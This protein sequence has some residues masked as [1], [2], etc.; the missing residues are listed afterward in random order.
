M[1][2]YTDNAQRAFHGRLLVYLQA[3]GKEETAEVEFSA[4]WLRKAKIAI[5]CNGKK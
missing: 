4:P 5:S 3:T 2:N 1:G